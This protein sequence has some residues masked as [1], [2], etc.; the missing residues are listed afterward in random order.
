VLSMGACCW[1]HLC[2]YAQGNGTTAGSPW[3][4]QCTVQDQLL[5]T[6]N[7]LTDNRN[8]RATQL[9]RPSKA[10]VDLSTGGRGHH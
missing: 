2:D 5:D 7:K 6:L 1:M 9:R 10:G 3:W 4:R 8:L